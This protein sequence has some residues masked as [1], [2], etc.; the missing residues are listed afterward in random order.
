MKPNQRKVSSYNTKS[1]RQR[2]EKFLRGEK[3]SRLLETLTSAGE[4]G[5]TFTAL[6][7]ISGLSRSTVY[8]Y[9]LRLSELEIAEKVDGKWRAK[10]APKKLIEEVEVWFDNFEKLDEPLLNIMIERVTRFMGKLG[11]GDFFRLI[12]DLVGKIIEEEK[13][14]YA[15]FKFLNALP[16]QML[17]HRGGDLKNAILLYLKEKVGGDIKGGEEAVK[18]ASR[19]LEA[20]REL[21]KGGDIEKIEKWRAAF[22]GK[23]LEIALEN[24]PP[25]TG[26]KY[27]LILRLFP[28]RKQLL[29]ELLNIYWKTRSEKVKAE[30]LNIIR[31]LR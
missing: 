30:I 24:I 3:I 23:M 8:R 7:K 27:D 13:F 4:E 21:Y 20:E 11:T 28:S 25:S 17:L 18:L 22:P 16:P 5:L 15:T 19:L 29:E 9:L 6:I 2:R 1:F 31:T 26:F 12:N 14:N 10:S